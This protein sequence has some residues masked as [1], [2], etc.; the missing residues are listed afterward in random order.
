[1]APA[2]IASKVRAL[3]DDPAFI[4]ALPG[5]LLPDAGSQARRS[6]LEARLRAL[7]GETSRRSSR[8]R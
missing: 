1:M 4:E 7:C 8:R 2:Y 5:F 3:P 6:I